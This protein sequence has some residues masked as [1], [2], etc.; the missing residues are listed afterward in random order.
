VE[1][2]GGVLR[3]VDYKTGKVEQNEVSLKAT[4]EED[5]LDGKRG[6]AVQLFAY[7]AMAAEAPVRAAI[8]SGRYARSGLLELNVEKEPL[9]S[10]DL[11]QQFVDR[12]GEAL[13]AR[14]GEAREVDHH[15]DAHYCPYCVVLDPPPAWE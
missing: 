4:W 13:V 2:E 10:E 15:P 8:R 11:V 3:I 7:C 5:L 12:V 6:K 14:L 1:R 9:L